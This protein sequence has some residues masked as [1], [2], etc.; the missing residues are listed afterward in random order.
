MW[1]GGLEKNQDKTN[2]IES[3]FERDTRM[4]SSLDHLKLLKLKN[5][6]YGINSKVD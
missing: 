6:N 1:W 3:M 2:V 4:L 5:L